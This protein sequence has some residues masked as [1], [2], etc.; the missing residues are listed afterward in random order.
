MANPHSETCSSLPLTMDAD[1]WNSD[2]LKDSVGADGRGLKWEAQALQ[3]PRSNPLSELDHTRQANSQTANK[4]GLQDI[5]TT[6]GLSLLK[7]CA[8][9]YPGRKKGI[10]HINSRNCEVLTSANAI[11]LGRD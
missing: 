5:P 10:S 2:H 6:N 8:K 3:N 4:P 11:P 9:G 1:I 7:D